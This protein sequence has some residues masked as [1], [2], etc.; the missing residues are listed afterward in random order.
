MR[1]LEKHADAFAVSCIHDKRNFISAITKLGD[2]NLS[3]PSHSK[4]VELFLYTHPPISKRLR[5]ARNK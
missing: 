5:Y 2:Q 3:D 4:F 1:H